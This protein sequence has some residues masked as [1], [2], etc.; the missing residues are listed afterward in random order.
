LRFDK[1]IARYLRSVLVELEKERNEFASFHQP[2]V[3]A[4][5]NSALNN[6]IGADFQAIG[7]PVQRS[8]VTLTPATGERTLHDIFRAVRETAVHEVGA[9]R[10]RYAVA[11]Y[12]K[13]YT[14]DVFAVWAYVVAL[15]PTR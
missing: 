11:T 5:Q 1:G 6:I 14:K 12:V 9:P 13:G 2:A 8:Y 3:D 4:E 10:L 15:V 7:Y